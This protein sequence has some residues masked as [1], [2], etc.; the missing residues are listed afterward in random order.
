M[1]DRRE[2]LDLAATLGLT[3]HVVEKDYALGWALAGI[4][5]HPELAPTWVFK[6]GTCLKKC[7][8]ETYRFSEDLD[9]TLQDASH[10]DEAFLQRVFSEVS[11]WIYEQSGLEFPPDSQDF[12]ILTN[13]RGNP[14][15]Q[16][17]LSYRGPVSPRSPPRIKLDLTADERIVLAP[18]Q[19]PIFHP[20]SDAPDEGFTVQ[21]YA[22]EEAF[23][24]KIRALAERTRPRDLYDVVNL[25]RN[26]EA[27]PAAT[28]LLDVLR[29]K[30]EFKGIPVPQ[31]DD[32]TL[33]RGEVEGAWG[34]MLDHQLPSLPPVATFWDALPEFF[35]WLLGGEPVPVPAAY[36]LA[37]GDTVIRDRTLLIPVSGR[38][39]SH[40]EIIRFSAA[41][42][43]CVEFDYVDEKGRHST[44]VIEP[45]SLRR[46]SEDNIILH[47][48]D[49][50]KD[51]H[52]S[53]R[54]DRIGGARSTGRTFLP[55]Y[56]VELTPSGPVR[57]P[58][59]DR[60]AG[61]GTDFGT[62]G[63]LGSSPRSRPA[64]TPRGRAVSGFGSGPTFVYQCGM[65]GKKF[66]RK[67]MD[68]RLNKHKAPGG[69]PCSSRTGFLVDTKY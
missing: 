55:R 5:A 64:R 30:C 57:I 52:R 4:Y 38:S 14:S 1:I 51:A 17:K 41:N 16:A 3:P 54:V 37:E 23:G 35:R 20:Y 63:S 39:Q 62:S 66:N 59:T 60:G 65:C 58:P 13:P 11:E 46:T 53:F 43:L 27:R 25:F 68:G 33:H 28:V 61:G 9:F 15:C 31:L 47:T 49:V 50:D 36:R 69:F 48:W 40:L 10:L 67:T 56:E 24:E 29:Q 26:T 18:V 12:E 45:Y 42:R 34:H 6:G 22:Y 7:Y 8:F 19:T 21:A 32:L 44:R 2:I